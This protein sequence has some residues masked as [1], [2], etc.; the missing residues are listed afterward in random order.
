MS[1]KKDAKTGIW[2][3][4]FMVNGERVRFS[5]QT[6][7][8]ALAQHLHD[9]AK[10][11]TWE[12]QKLG[13][14]PEYTVDDALDKLLEMSANQRDFETKVSHAAYW[15]IALGC[16]KL[17][18][19]TADDILNKL[20][21]INRNTGKAISPATQNRYRCSIMRAL[22]LARQAGWIDV[23]PYVEKNVEPKKRVR[24]ISQ[25]EA[26][27]LINNLSKSQKGTQWMKDVVIF[28]LM[29]GARKSEILSLTWDKVDLS[30][31]IAIIS[32]DIAKNGI[33]RSIPLNKEAINLLRRKMLTRKSK[34][35]FHNGNGKRLNDINRYC[36]EKALALSGISDFR[37]HDLR[38]TWASWHV[39]S[40]TP[41]LTLK[42]LGG[43]ETIEIVQRYAH[44]NVEHLLSYANTVKFLSNT[45]IIADLSDAKNEV[46]NSVQEEKRKAVSY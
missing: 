2:Y 40:G 46:F 3:I 14:K 42:E 43:W 25:E 27:R 31:S 22:N 5:S 8:K 37:F 9:K 23:I 30:H 34:Y 36:F 10:L 7:N 32:G 20:P 35:I 39:Q 28:A 44:L 6:T 41:L 13:R 19:I 11:E 1:I 17:S 33:E 15:R 38:H 26:R 12:R 4:N 21:K 24:W 18:D 45:Q 16:K 29:T